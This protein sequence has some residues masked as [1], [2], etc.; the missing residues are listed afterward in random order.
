MMSPNGTSWSVSADAWEAPLEVVGPE[1]DDQ[2]PIAHDFAARAQCQHE[3]LALQPVIPDRQAV[4]ACE[5]RELRPGRTPGRDA[6]RQ[7]RGS[8]SDFHRPGLY[9]KLPGRFDHGRVKH[10]DTQLARIL[11]G[12]RQLARHERLIDLEANVYVLV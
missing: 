5:V 12:C 4:A 10:A 8:T 2:R 7:Q 3:R 9:Q 11:R 1:P 6:D